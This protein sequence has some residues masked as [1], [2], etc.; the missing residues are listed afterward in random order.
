M[1]D[2]KDLTRVQQDVILDF[3]EGS[4]CIWEGEGD[5]EVLGLI[6]HWGLAKGDPDSPMI[7]KERLEAAL[8]GAEYTPAMVG[9]PDQ[10]RAMISILDIEGF[11]QPLGVKPRHLTVPQKKYTKAE[12]EEKYSGVLGLHAKNP[13]VVKALEEYATHP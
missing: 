11:Q 3:P 1:T 6:T 7:S 10:L 2:T 9:T 4:F 8:D 5:E 12:F 13:L